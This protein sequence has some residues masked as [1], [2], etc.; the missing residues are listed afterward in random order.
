M[1]ATAGTQVI[2]ATSRISFVVAV[3]SFL[4]FICGLAM[5]LVLEKLY[6]SSGAGFGLY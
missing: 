2:A 6:M 1:I 3:L 4:V 5:L